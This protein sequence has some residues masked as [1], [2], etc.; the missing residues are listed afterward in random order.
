M[1][2][3]LFAISLLALLSGCASQPSPTPAPAITS[4]VPS[5]SGIPN[6]VAILGNFEFISVQGTGQIF[7]YNIATGSQIAGRPALRNPLH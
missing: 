6:S 3:Y 4:V 2:V 1:H 7:T 5:A